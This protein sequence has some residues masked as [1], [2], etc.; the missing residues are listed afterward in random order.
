MPELKIA[1][2]KIEEQYLD[3]EHRQINID[4]GY[5]T[6]AKIV[7]ATTKNY[8][9]RL[10]LARGI[11]GDLHMQ[12]Q[13]G[14]YQ[15]NPWTYPDYKQPKVRSFFNDVRKTFMAQLSEFAK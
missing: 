13:K 11:F 4:P 8:S 10:Y 3:D 1:S 6:A 12:Y 7:L 5:L 9:H 2:N 14:N 15:P